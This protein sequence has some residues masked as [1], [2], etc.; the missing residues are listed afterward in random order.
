M[1]LDQAGLHAHE[2]QIDAFDIS[3]RLLTKAKRDG[4]PVLVRLPEINFIDDGPG[5]QFLDRVRDL[6]QEI[7]RVGFNPEELRHVAEFNLRHPDS[8]QTLTEQERRPGP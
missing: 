5:K 3:P 6:V 7:R 1:A 4:R 8:F 2:Y